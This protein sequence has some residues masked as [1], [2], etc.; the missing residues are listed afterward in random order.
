MWSYQYKH[1]D[2]PL[3]GYTIQSAAGRG[4]F[5]EVYYAVSDAGREVALKAVTG[6]EQI[7]IRGI[8][9]CMNLKSPHLVS[10]FDVKYNAQ[11]KPFVIMEFVSGP[12][13]RQLIDESPS[14]LGEQ[15]AAFFLREIGKGLTFLHECGIVHRD[16]KPGNIFYENGYV[17]IGDY[18]L[19]KAIATSPHSGQTVTVGTV[20][21]M[22]PEVG[23]GKYDRG[24]DIY[25][26]GAVLYEMLTGVPPFV[27]ASP[28]EV[29]LKHLSVQPDCTGISEPFATV[30]KRAMAKDPTQRF[31]SVQEMVEAVFGAEHVQQSM[32]VFSPE[33]LSMV[34]GRAA[35][36]VVGST[37]AIKPPPLP[38]QPAGTAVKDLPR[39]P[40][41]RAAARLDRAGERMAEGFE[42]IGERLSQR[43]GGPA[44]PSSNDPSRDFTVPVED[45]LP[46]HARGKLVLLTI[47]IVSAAS[48][49]LSP[50][51][52]PSQDPFQFGVTVAGSIGLALFCFYKLRPRM[53]APEFSGRGA[54][55]LLTSGITALG[56][57]IVPMM[58]VGS[59]S[60]KPEVL[61]AMIAPLFI[62][63]L[64][65]ITRPDRP[66][67]VN[68]GPVIAAGAIAFGLSIPLDGPEVYLI[69]AAAG[70]MLALQLGA[71]WQSRTV[72]QM[73]PHAAAAP[74]GAAPRTVNA[75]PTTP[76]S[77]IQN[78]SAAEAATRNMSGAS[79][80]EQVWWAP[81]PSAVRY[82]W[83]GVS[84]LLV[85][86]C[87]AFFVA[88][89]NGRPR[90]FV[91]FCCIG[92]GT[93]ALAL[94]SLFRTFTHRY[95]GI[96]NYLIR[97]VLL[98]A[99]LTATIATSIAA[100]NLPLRN[101]DLA[102]AVFFIIFPALLFVVLLF[103]PGKRM[104]K[105][106][107]AA[108]AI[109][110]QGSA[111]ATAPTPQRD[112]ASAISPFKRMW[113]LVLSLVGFAGVCGLQRFYVGKIGTGILWLFTGGFF[114]IGQLVD[115][116]LITSGSFTDKQ[117]RRL[118]DWDSESE[119]AF[120]QA[121][122]PANGPQYP[123]ALRDLPSPRQRGNLGRHGVGLLSALAGLMIFLGTLLGLATAVNI[124]NAINAGV[125]GMDVK[126][127]ILRD[128]FNGYD[129][130]PGLVTRMATLTLGMIFLIATIAM[131]FA[132][133]RGGW[134]HQLRG[135]LGIAA[136]LV[137]IQVVSQMFRFFDWSPIAAFV[138]TDQIPA[139][140]DY[141][142]KQLGQGH[143]I[144]APL[145]L[146]AA[147]AMFA[148][149][150][151][152]PSSPALVESKAA[153][154]PSAGGQGEVKV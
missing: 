54:R 134:T 119:T 46:R 14:G 13:L 137:C 85:S 91:P 60:N 84:I 69:A 61:L 90:E 113:A 82:I 154:V 51:R 110:P 116:I 33:E 117:G 2:R 108:P 140:I 86:L 112:P 109:A 133:R 53:L 66:D 68:L 11:G 16:L 48:A 98:W 40:W 20:H 57:I 19:S 52:G 7:E 150:A 6:Y 103:I 31:Q 4:G 120:A 59:N 27:G 141:S 122:A 47:L 115:V 77:I 146:I 12:S 32:S 153:D 44:K 67:R 21:Y 22:A 118:V 128:V 71:P 111:P 56:A 72:A 23:A 102:I 34:A 125:F 74:A 78:A 9:Q 143:G 151:R 124:P 93:A 30:I 65:R 88:A 83:A 39:D 95:Y 3:E 1:G 18:G 41:E 127:D 97:P 123:P 70:T 152:K 25:A 105:A 73:T 26:L 62:F 10:I 38:Q 75:L 37:E 136:L 99:T 106:P 17:K 87:I 49:I 92:C 129:G 36:Q 139:A 42:R 5:G 101:E 45:V 29:L 121:P 130:W 76:Q 89:G 15:K 104:W 135:F 58:I 147:V 138:S 114:G 63:D 81:V 145:W 142:L 64:E 148:W 107:L 96:W 79:G 132:R 55:R 8:G 43:L 100:G 24:I 126:R 35:K 28:S 80:I 50:R 144:I 94:L 131:I 149:P